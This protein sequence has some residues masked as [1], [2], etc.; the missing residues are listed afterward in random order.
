MEFAAGVGLLQQREPVPEHGI[1]G[2]LCLIVA[3]VTGV[4]LF[5]CKE[6]L[7]HQGIQID[8][9]RVPCKCRK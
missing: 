6:L 5:P 7:L 4:D 1:I 2:H 3:P 9:I 8:K